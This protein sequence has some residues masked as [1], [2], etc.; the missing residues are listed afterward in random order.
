MFNVSYVSSHPCKAHGGKMPDDTSTFTRATTFVWF[1]RL[2]YPCS[3]S[4]YGSLMAQ[5][6]ESREHTQ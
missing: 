4:L 5:S 1:R 2:L 6:H 3:R